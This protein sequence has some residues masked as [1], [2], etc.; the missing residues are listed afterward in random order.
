VNAVIRSWGDGPHVPEFRKVKDLLSFI[1]NILQVSLFIY[2]TLAFFKTRSLDQG[3]S[4]FTFALYRPPCEYLCNSESWNFIHYIYQDIDFRNIL[5]NQFTHTEIP[6]TLGYWDT[7]ARDS[8]RTQGRICY[9]LFDFDLSR[10]VPPD[11]SFRLSTIKGRGSPWLHPSSLYAE[12]IDLES[13]PELDPF[14]FDVACMGNMLTS[15]YDVRHLSIILHI[16]MPI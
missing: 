7:D 8:L 4:F 12:N 3:T 16:Q 13:D 5:V 15:S 10:L 11:K 2:V 9:C 6:D 1:E 14:K